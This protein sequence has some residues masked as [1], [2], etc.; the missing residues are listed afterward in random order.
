MHD[1]AMEI[2][3]LVMDRYADLAR[4]KVLELGSLDVN[5]SLRRHAPQTTEYVGLDLEA[6]PGV[7]F[8]V[9]AGRPWP[10]KD[11]YFDLVFAS[12]VFEH[13]AMFWIT[14]LQMI[15]K[16]KRGGYI[17]ISA[18]SNG[19]VHRHPQDSWRFYPDSGVALM[20]WA[21]SQGHP[22]SLIESFIAGRKGDQWNDFVAIFRKGKEKKNLPTNFVYGEFSSFNVLTWQSDELINPATLTEDMLIMNK[23]G[24]HARDLEEKLAAASLEGQQNLQR[25]HDLEQDITVKVAQLSQ[26][27]A[28]HAVSRKE[29]IELSASAERKSAEI[30]AAQADI[31]QQRDRLLAQE[32][33]NAELAKQVADQEAALAE[34]DALSTVREA[35]LEHLRNELVA[36]SAELIAAGD[37]GKQLESELREREAAAEVPIQELAQLR[38]RLALAESTLLQ[39][40]EEI[41]QTRVELERFRREYEAAVE[42]RSKLEAKLSEADAWVFK[43]AGERKHWESEVD[44]ANR[45][46][47]Q[48]EADARERLATMGE[49]LN[50]KE[51]ELDSLWALAGEMELQLAERQREIGQLTE[52]LERS[53]RE[54]DSFRVT[55]SKREGQLAARFNEIAELTRAL[56]H[57]ESERE[58]MRRHISDIELQLATHRSEISDL[59][60][61]ILQSEVRISRASADVQEKAAE[62]ERVLAECYRLTE[63]LSIAERTSTEAGEKLAA[64]HNEIARI[65]V[66]LAERAAETAEA[67]A[68][69]EWLRRM[70][71]ISENTPFWWKLLPVK[72]RRSK[73]HTY[74]L[75]QGLFDAMS[76]LEAYPDVVQDGM[77][78][79]RHYI[80]HGIEEGR[81]I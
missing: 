22:V 13:D 27:Q 58:E 18:P 11:N 63:A 45:K 25:L 78:P 28:A 15:Q 6:G 77:D 30:Q 40:V 49:R 42:Q 53:R 7:D 33:L 56:G 69:A 76:Y 62:N 66:M 14:F 41:E 34:A 1:T 81:R 3:C 75:R 47:S 5:G 21:E 26:E 65:T 24:A 73:E 9:E 64:R 36:R 32:T 71:M 16:T 55:A 70:A 48:S 52:A 17:Y 60:Q 2:G 12:S 50:D 39:R 35:E 54:A 72:W 57:N 59:K 37:L 67:T 29:L 10:V 8:V 46:L 31:A 20:R 61:E 44:R 80:F 23:I 38:D 74:L 68:K 43:L 51:K 4:A 19:S 79:V